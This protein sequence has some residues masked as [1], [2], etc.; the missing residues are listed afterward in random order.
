MTITITV[1][2]S[3]AAKPGE[4]EYQTAEE[5]GKLIAKAGYVLKNGG[6]GGTMEASA[7]GAQ[8]AGGETIG[9][10]LKG[11]W[12][13][14][15]NKWLSGK[16]FTGDLFQRLKGLIDG[17]DAFIV[18][19]GSSGTLAE[20]SLILEMIAKKIVPVVPV[21]FIGDFWTPFLDF[22]REIS[23]GAAKIFTVVEGPQEALQH[24]KKTLE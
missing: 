22:F 15:G 12:G 8:L 9:I 17:A 16:V 6:Y 10:L 20:I 7:K 2:G 13:N 4:S 3:S 18:L 11:Y 21:V 5:I 24:I 14:E 23:P 19:P 1:F